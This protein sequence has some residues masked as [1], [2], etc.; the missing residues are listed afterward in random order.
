MLFR[1][2]LWGIG[3]LLVITS[4]VHARCQGQ[5][6]R[7][8]TITVASRDGIARS[9]VFRNRRVSSH[10]GRSEDASMILTFPSASVGVQVLLARNAVLQ[11]CRG[12]TAKEIDLIG[13][14]ARVLWFYEMVI[15]YLPWRRPRYHKAPNAYI[16]HDPNSKA[17]DRITRE[18]AVQELDPG[19]TAAIAQR[20]K[21]DIWRV[22]KGDLSP[23]RVPGFRYLAE[24][25]AEALQE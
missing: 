10:A 6:T 21:T 7:D 24:I 25:P 19:W 11:I 16:A 14:P 17:A 2:V 20:E 13:A 22:A 18:P 5:L 8:M 1:I 12:L 9:F 15:H 23:G 3:T 4:R